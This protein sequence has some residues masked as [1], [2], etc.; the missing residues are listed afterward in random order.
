MRTVQ[1]GDQV[2]VHY[3]KRFPDGSVVSSRSRGDAPLGLTAGTDHPRLPGLGSG[4]VGS[5]PGDRVTLIVPAEQA[6]GLPDPS[7]IRRLARKRFPGDQALPVG[8]WVRIL[9]QQRRRRLVRIVEVGKRVVVVDTNHR[10]AGQAMDLE[11]EVISIQDPVAGA[12]GQGRGAEK[13]AGPH[14]GAGE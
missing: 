10:R 1:E 9:D 4:L 6:Y 8:K 7:R 13:A 14:P 12:D 11:V 2:Q 5:A 3:V